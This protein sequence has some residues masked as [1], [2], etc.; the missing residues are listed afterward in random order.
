MILTFV[1]VSFQSFYAYINLFIEKIHIFKFAN[2]YEKQKIV[3]YFTFL[4]MHHNFA[5]IMTFFY[6]WVL[7][8]VKQKLYWKYKKF[9]LYVEDFGGGEIHKD[10]RVKLRLWCL[11]ARSKCSWNS[12]GWSWETSDKV[13]GGLA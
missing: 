10:T 1:C 8:R 9:K 11:G 13:F 4:N 6:K 7:L 12:R 5:K 2:K 3:H